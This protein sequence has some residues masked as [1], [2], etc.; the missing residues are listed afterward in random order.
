MKTT[1]K[2]TPAQNDD[3]PQGPRG[4]STTGT[5]RWVK[6]FGIIALI[7][8]VLVIIAH[9]SGYGLGHHMSHSNVTEHGGQ[10]P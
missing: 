1:E 7:L 10:Q 5:P 8:I 6:F 3:N 4:V 9:L 2:Q